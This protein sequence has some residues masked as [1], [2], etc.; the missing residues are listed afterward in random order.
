M[1]HVADYSSG[2]GEAIAQLP[3]WTL[4]AQSQDVKEKS[5]FQ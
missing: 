1:S 2:T 5:G 3:V 4:V